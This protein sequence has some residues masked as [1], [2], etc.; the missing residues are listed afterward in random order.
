MLSAFRSVGCFPFAVLAT[1]DGGGEPRCSSPNARKKTRSLQRSEAPVL[2]F[3]PDFTTW[4]TNRLHSLEKSRLS[5]RPGG[6]RFMCLF[7][8][9]LRS[10][11]GD[12]AARPCA[13]WRWP[14]GAWS[15]RWAGR[16]PPTSV[17]SA[18]S[19]GGWWMSQDL[20]SGQFH[21][22]PQQLCS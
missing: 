6:E 11:G 16:P 4:K 12:G 1:A 17:A 20:S 22:G 2:R 18:T 10:G 8:R 21:R 13:P 3:D 19:Q 15:L 9:H 14:G 7:H 5:T